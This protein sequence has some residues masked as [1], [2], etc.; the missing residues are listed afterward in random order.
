MISNSIF[1][2]REI[3]VFVPAVIFNIINLNKQ[4]NPRKTFLKFS[5]KHIG[6]I[7]M[8]GP[9]EFPKGLLRLIK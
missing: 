3:W 7:D 6:I 5:D 2:N 9:P 4:V 8:I 1:R